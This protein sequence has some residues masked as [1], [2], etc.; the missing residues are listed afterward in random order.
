M[1][2]LVFDDVVYA[3]RFLYRHR[4]IVMRVIVVVSESSPYR[5][6]ALKRHYHAHV[7]DSDSLLLLESL[8]DR[9]RET[10]L[11]VRGEECEAK[12]GCEG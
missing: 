8:T 3:L 5:L 11:K 7:V 6:A 4:S 1:R 12:R 9:L 2:I 10:L